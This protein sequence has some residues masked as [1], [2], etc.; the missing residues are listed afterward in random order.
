MLIIGTKAFLT[1]KSVAFE[2]AV[3]LYTGKNIIVEL[4]LLVEILASILID[5][6]PTNPYSAALLEEIVTEN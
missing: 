3:E 1:T 2:V 5:E 4:P 6:P